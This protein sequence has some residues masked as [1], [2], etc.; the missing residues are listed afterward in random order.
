MRRIQG[1]AALCAAAALVAISGCKDILR[2]QNPQAFTDD[3]ANNPLLL[4][5]VAAGAE[6]DFQ[7]SLD[8]LLIFSGLLSDEFWHVGAWIDWQDVSTGK[9]RPNWPQNNSNTFNDAENNMLLARG[10][11]ASG[12]KRFER[13]MK[14]TARFSPLFVTTQ[15]ARAWS[16]LYLAMSVCQLPPAPNMAMVSD[17]VIFKQA[18]D[19]FAA[20]LPIIA[21]AH[22]SKPSDRQ[23][24][25]N[26]ANAG[27][28][29]AN[30]MIGNYPAALAY[31][32]AVPAGFKYIAIYSLNS[33]FQNNQMANQGNANYNRSYS[34][35]GMWHQYIDTIAGQMRDPYSGQLDPRL[36]LGHDNNNA[37]GYD[38]GTDGVT[39]F[40]S[41]NKYTSYA[42]PI[43]VSKSEE[44]NLI[45]AEV[46]WRQGSFQ[47]ALDAMN[48]NRTAVGLPPMT[49]PTSGDVSLQVRDLLLQERFAVLFGEGAR[50]NDLYRFGLVTKR[51]G[52]NR[53]TKLPL[54]RT[55]QLG[56]PAI[57]DGKE[58]CPAVS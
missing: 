39:K 8:N 16:D 53:A 47:A 34:I 56:N 46:R 6:G 55:E 26:Q 15:L 54:S 36:P 42:S 13:V 10:T 9:I 51:L 50:L 32:Q 25:L 24:R 12:S 4:P 57:G 52:A 20:L 28:A 3:A 29:R 38:K 2:V 48:T 27:A 40:Y 5:A 30:L 43:S 41:I 19:S 14:D 18:A 7:V 45:V 31:A 37:R 11:A 1:V 35:R 33:G 49:L 22:Y 44:M 58:T 23:D 21:A 17:S